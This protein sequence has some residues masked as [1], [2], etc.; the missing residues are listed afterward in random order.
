MLDDN[1]MSNNGIGVDANGGSQ[2][3][4][5]NNMITSN[6]TGIVGAT[7]SHGNNRIDAN[8]GAGTPPTP[9]GQQ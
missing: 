5:A 7:S 3:F 1:I 6:N 4:L 8:V 9:I 2:V